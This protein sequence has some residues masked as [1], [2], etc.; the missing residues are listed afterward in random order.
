MLASGRHDAGEARDEAL[1]DPGAVYVRAPR[2]VPATVRF[3]EF[4]ARRLEAALVCVAFDVATFDPPPGLTEFTLEYPFFEDLRAW[5]DA[6]SAWAREA[7]YDV[8][9]TSSLAPKTIDLKSPGA[10]DRLEALVKCSWWRG[11]R[12]SKLEPAASWMNQLLTRSEDAVRSPNGRLPRMLVLVTGSFTPERWVRGDPE[13]ATF[14]AEWR[15]KLQP[16]GRYFEEG[17]VGAVLQ[18]AG[19]TLCVVAPEARF[20]DFAP[21]V[22]LPAVPWAARPQLPPDD[23][24]ARIGQGRLL[25]GGVGRRATGAL[26]K[27]LEESYR[28]LYPDPE[29]RRQKVEEAL[30]RIRQRAGE[31]AP[32]TPDPLGRFPGVVPAHDSGL[33][34]VATTP[35][36]FFMFD[37]HVPVNDHA[38]SGYGFWPLAR[39]AAKTGG[40]YVFYPFPETPWLDVCPADGALL[41]RLA[42]ELVSRQRYLALRRGDPAL[43]AVGR[44]TSLVLD[45]TPWADSGYSNRLARH[46]TALVRTG[47]LRFEKKVPPRRKPYDDALQGSERGTERLGCRLRDEVL[48]RY[49][50]ALAIL[51]AAVAKADDWKDR[52][53]PRSIAHLRLTRYWMAMSAFHLDA[54]GIY[55][56]EIQRFIPPSVAGHVDRIVVT[57]VPAIKMSDCLDAYDGRTLSIDEEKAY[58][59]WVPGDAPG[60]QGNLLRIPVDDPNYRAKRNIA[61]VLRHLDPR[62]RRRALVMIEAARDVMR[63]YAK[64]GWGWTTY[65]SEAYTFIFKPLEVPRGHRPSRGG[66]KPLPRPT[67]PR[68]GG[69]GSGG[70]T[71]GGPATG[72]GR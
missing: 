43:D 16:V 14:E 22:E 53:H 46:W 59:R 8:R 39:A 57:Y 27:A 24:L 33:R 63:D 48:P 49:D 64:T 69:P 4:E 29:E 19:C 67:T 36:W 60:Y 42:P 45:E 32:T 34:Y 66:G 54:Y 58:P 71:A 50:K 41:N 31:R 11:A 15:T 40:R 7:E 52:A 25:Q 35:V 13:R 26:R 23:L 28:D 2:D 30:E 17:K 47:P 1:P 12:P 72:G 51:D 62:L 5:I 68:G 70:S 20:G 9:G 55:A 38:P 44:A 65:Y 18:R 6:I 37:A 61:S 10:A 56:R 21:F 3:L